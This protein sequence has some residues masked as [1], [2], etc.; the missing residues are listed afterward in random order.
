M[1]ELGPRF[2]GDGPRAEGG[3]GKV[4]L[5]PIHVLTRPTKGSADF[6]TF[7]ASIFASIF[8]LIFENGFQNGRS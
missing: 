5:P 4:N 7:S 8:S 3:R 6:M 1:D 2:G